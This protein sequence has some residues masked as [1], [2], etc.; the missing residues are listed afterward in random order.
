M[1]PEVYML[2]IALLYHTVVWAFVLRLV[3]AVKDGA[4]VMDFL[5]PR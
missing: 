1:I 2:Y 5:C 4:K 3:D